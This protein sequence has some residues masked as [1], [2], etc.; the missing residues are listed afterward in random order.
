MAVSLKLAVTMR[1]ELHLCFLPQRERCRPSINFLCQDCLGADKALSILSETHEGEASLRG[2]LSRAF[3][4]CSD[5][6][7]P[8]MH[9]TDRQKEFGLKL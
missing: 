7:R 2:A 1:R 6:L 5:N 4:R 9:T 3:P 8:Q